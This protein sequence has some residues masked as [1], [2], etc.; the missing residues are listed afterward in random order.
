MNKER[1]PH[2][3]NEYK[4]V[5]DEIKNLLKDNKKLVIAID[6]RCGGGKSSLGAMLTEEF[7][8]SLF[9]MDDF[10][11]PPRM[12][13]KERLAEPGGNVHYERFEEEI[14]KPL[15]NDEPA[16]YRKYLCNKG[17]LSQPIKVEPKNLTIVEGSYSLHPTLRDYYDYKIFITIDSKVQHERILKR[18]GEEKLQD[19]INKWI[20]LEEHYFT[21][22]DIENKCDVIFDTTNIKR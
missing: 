11:L 10:F 12:K 4:Y 22:L 13:T 18:N 3:Y 21:E 20:P 15:K 2:I 1:K 14:L 7:D 17:E 8:C 19:F 6:G 5:F 9:H 16:I